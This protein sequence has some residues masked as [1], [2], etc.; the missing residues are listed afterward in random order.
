MKFTPTL[1]NKPPMRSLVS[2]DDHFQMSPHARLR[3]RR[4]TYIQARRG[5]W[6]KFEWLLIALLLVAL[7]WSALEILM[8]NWTVTP[9]L[10]GSMRPG[11]P[12]GGVAVAERVPMHDLALGDVILFQDPRQHSREMV[13]RVIQLSESA[14]GYPVIRTKGDANSIADPWV[15]TLHGQSIDVVQ[16]T[17]PLLGYPAVYTDHGVDLMVSG[18]ILLCVFVATSL[19]IVRRGKS[20]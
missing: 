18:L 20:M 2:P 6:V 15:V 19:S 9:I 4:V 14:R 17:I 3:R 10:S 7:A 13:H 1:D 5:I 11:F 8:G 16:F 12:V